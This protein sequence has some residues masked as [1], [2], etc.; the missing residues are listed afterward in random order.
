VA[1]H[2]EVTYFV[3]LQADQPFLLAR[4]RWPDVYQA[5]SPARPEWQDDI[6]LFDLP[7]DPASVA[8]TVKQAAAIAARWGARPPA[9][10]PPATPK[11]VLVRRMPADWS[12]LSRAERDAWSIEFGRTERRP[13]RRWGRRKAGASPAPDERRAGIQTNVIDLTEKS[14]DTNATDATVLDLTAMNGTAVT[15]VEDA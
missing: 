1:G 11:P 5:M 9:D 3:M 13:G 8:V 14:H 4:V 2:H 10:V 15:T 6:G 7:Y 12:H